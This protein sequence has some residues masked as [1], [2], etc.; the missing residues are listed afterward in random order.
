MER[1]IAN[2]FIEYKTGFLAGKH[3]I[4]EAFKLGKVI[5]LK[6]K[7]TQR[8]ENT[9]WFNCGYEDGFKYF[10]KIINNFQFY[11]EGL[12]TREITE[13]SFTNR[14]LEMNQETGKEIPVGKFRI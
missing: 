14:I 7:E 5:D 10:S 12:N 9:F 1:I 8:Q 6:S 3:E 11:L 13:Q 4:V 2:E